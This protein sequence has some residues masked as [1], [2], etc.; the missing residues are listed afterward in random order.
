M[1]SEMGG[2]NG[3]DI[4]GGGAG[5]RQKDLHLAPAFRQFLHVDILKK[6]YFSILCQVGTT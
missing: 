5:I 4:S 6:G 1:H 2:R 3:G